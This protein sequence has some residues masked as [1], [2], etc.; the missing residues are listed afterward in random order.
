MECLYKFPADPYFS[1]TGMRITLDDKEIEAVILAKEEAQEKYDDAVAAG[2]TAAK[3]NY[4]ENVPE[5]IELAIGALQPDKAVTIAVHMVAK[6]DVIQHGF[7]SFIFPV[8]F[9]PQ[10][11]ADKSQN[12]YVPNSIRSAGP[13]ATTSSAPAVLG[14][15]I[16]GKFSCS[17]TV[18]ASNVISDLSVS[19][20][21]ME[22]SQ[23]EDG[24]TVTIKLAEASQVIAR[25]IV[26]SYSTEQIREPCIA[27]H[28][29]DR[30]PDEVAA[31]ISFIPRVSDEHGVDEDDEETKAE[32]SA[33]A[34][35]I[36]EPVDK[37]DPD[38]ASGEF[39]FVLDRSGS[40]QGTRIERAKEA[41]TLFIQSLPTDSLFNIVSFG[42]KHELMYP[43]SQKY[44]KKAIDE[45]L[46]KI[47]HIKANMGGTVMLA[48]LETVFKKKVDH[49]YPK[50]IFIL[51]DGAIK[52]T[53]QVVAKIR[54]YNHSVRVHTFGIGSGAS[55]Y[56][57]K[58]TAK[59]GL[60]TSAL[61]AD[62]DTQVKAK[63]IQALK[64]AAKPAFTDITLD[65]KDNAKAIKF[66]C[67]RPPIAGNIYEEEAFNIYAILKKDELA[68]GDLELS[69]FNTFDQSRGSLTLRLDTDKIVDSGE[70][71]SLFKMAAKEEIVHLQR[72][73]KEEDSKASDEAILSLS[74]EYSVLCDKTAFFGRIK[75]KEK[76]GEEMKTIKIPIKKMRDNSILNHNL[77]KYDPNQPVWA[78]SGMNKARGAPMMR[79][80]ATT[81]GVNMNSL[82]M[83]SVKKNYNASLPA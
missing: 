67:P 63:I 31:H 71:D 75:N 58:E 56:L 79:S 77:Y 12:A 73:L 50:N 65:W 38:I 20:K 78:C 44:T 25:D 16:P 54:Q 64:V 74:L 70:D 10:Y 27:L 6:C 40:M 39:I 11:D 49:K 19:H 26:V 32:E 83:I 76:S 69:F 8:N 41:L 14:S 1:V 82:G 9:I 21:A 7:F 60:G 66:Q 43:K 57:V 34:A 55:R 36:T 23:S 3:I 24:K 46:I 28:Q 45:T 51:T 4:D 48:P 61:I 53:D 47:K 30:H 22:H 35:E 5:V 59:A 37:D 80:K 15:Y 68:S 18:E 13:D 81:S 52:N 72:T 33:E 17:V 29:S 62:D 2:H 42:T